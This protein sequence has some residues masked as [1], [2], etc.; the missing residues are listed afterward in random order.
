MSD[1]A[2]DRVRRL[3]LTGDNRVKQGGGRLTTRARESFQAAL[4]LAEAEG[5]AD[6]RL[7][8]LIRLRLE[9]LDRA[10]DA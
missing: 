6:D 9:Q 8:T 2:R 5:I 10:A 1:D 3:I 4:D 7:R